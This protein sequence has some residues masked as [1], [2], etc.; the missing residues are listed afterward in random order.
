MA[1]P[2]FQVIMLPLLNFASVGEVRTLGDACEHLA[3]VF[4]LSDEEIAEL[5][6]SGR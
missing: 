5:L 2:E 4:A 1:I 6:P 3:S